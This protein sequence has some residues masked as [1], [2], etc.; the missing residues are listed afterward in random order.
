MLTYVDECHYCHA[1][2]NM[3]GIVVH[4]VGCPLKPKVQEQQWVISSDN[5]NVYQLISDYQAEIARLRAALADEERENKL[6]AQSLECWKSSALKVGQERNEA[7]RWARTFY[8]MAKKYQEISME[9]NVLVIKS[10]AGILN[11]PNLLDEQV[12]NQYPEAIN[13]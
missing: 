8:C 5:A 9:L 6:C 4:K 3:A 12:R 7:R 10:T 1:T 13:A 2:P 11:E